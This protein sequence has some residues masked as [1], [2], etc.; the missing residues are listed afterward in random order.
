[1][2][3]SSA[4]VLRLLALTLS[5]ASSLSV[6][7]NANRLR[8]WHPAH[9]PTDRPAP[10]TPQ[11]RLGAIHATDT[12]TAPPDA[13][14]EAAGTLDPVCGMTISPETAAASRSIEDVTYYFCS[15]H[16]A[17]TFDNDPARYTTTTA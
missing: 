2:R 14:P 11:V 9:P 13:G 12:A 5:L 1:M 6:V 15:G 8:R 17:A 16:C 10:V 7:A 3:R 4:F